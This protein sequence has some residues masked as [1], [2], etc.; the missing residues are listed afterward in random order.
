VALKQ[1]ARLTRNGMI[2]RAATAWSTTTV[3]MSDDTSRI[4]D[5]LVNIVGSFCDDYT[6][7]NPK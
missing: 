6:A 3:G 2:V 1:E 4:R 5:A 7:T